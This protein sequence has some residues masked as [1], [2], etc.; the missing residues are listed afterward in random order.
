MTVG[1][2]FFTEKGFR[3]FAFAC[4]DE[5]WK[6]LVPLSSWYFWIGIQPSLQRFEIRH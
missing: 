4:Q 6:S 5:F 1:S 2:H 3:V